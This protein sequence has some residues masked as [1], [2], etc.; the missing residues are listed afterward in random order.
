MILISHNSEM[1]YNSNIFQ[2]QAKKFVAENFVTHNVL[3]IFNHGLILI[4]IYIISGGNNIKHMVAYD[5]EI[6]IHG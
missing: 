6:Y 5:N 3:L 2:I 4:T 1:N